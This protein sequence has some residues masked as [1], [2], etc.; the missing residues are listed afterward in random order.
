VQ[1]TRPKKP[2]EKIITAGMADQ[3]KS[4][5]EKKVKSAINKG[6]GKCVMEFSAD[7]KEE[8][9]ISDEDDLLLS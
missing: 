5:D 2:G 7:V 4:L 9:P 6:L 8:E 3:W 1:Q